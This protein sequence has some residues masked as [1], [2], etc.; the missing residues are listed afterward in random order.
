CAGV[1]Q[2]GPGDSLQAVHAS[3]PAALFAACGEA[4]VRR[5]VHLSALGADRGASSFSASKRSGDEVLRTSD[6]QWAIL[7]PA[8]VIGA[9]AFG[10]AA[11]LRAL[12]ALPLLPVPRT[13]ALLRPVHIDDVVNTVL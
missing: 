8:I 13:T 1:L 10:G 4:G 12:A 11:L 2:D 5:V 6:L 7:R 9:N 3:G